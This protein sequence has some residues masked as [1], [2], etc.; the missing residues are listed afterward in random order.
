MTAPSIIKNIG[1]GAIWSVV[2]NS[3]TQILPLIVFL[4]TARFVSQEAFGIM[5][6]SILIVEAFRQIVVNP[7]GF[8]LIA[9]KDPSEEDYNACFITVVT[10]GSLFA[11]LIFLAAPL[12]ANVLGYPE[13][14]T[15]LHFV[16][17]MILFIGL[18]RV[19]EVWLIKNLQFKALASRSAASLFAGGA[20][21]IYMAVNGYGLASLIAQQIVT[22][23]TALIFLW[24]S[25]KW[26]P[27]FKTQWANIVELWRYTRFLMM[28]AVI[29]FFGMQTDTFF[30]G[31]YLGAAVTGTYNAAKRILAAL[32]MTLVQ[33]LNSVALPVFANMGSEGDRLGRAFLRSVRLTAIMAAP[34]YGG[35]LVLSEEAIHVL[36]GDNWLSAAPIMS[37]LIPAALISTISQY[38]ENIFLVHNKPQWPTYLTAVSAIINLG[39]FVLI[40][41]YGAV[42]LALA[43]SARAVIISPI[44]ISM[45]LYLL[46]LPLWHYIKQ[47]LPSLMAA[48]IMAICV[49]YLKQE[50]QS[51]HVLMRI[52][53]LVPVGAAIYI[54]A[55]ILLDRSIVKEVRSIISQVF[56]K[57]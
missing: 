14:E 33:A 17:P 44:N 56:K 40:A 46:K 23:I 29:S 24:A 53:I 12:L 48:T 25:T 45:A 49:Y 19:H 38:N 57:A 43:Y 21:G 31:Y 26:R 54:P 15:V 52:S 3:L 13:V 50:L 5:A 39:L 10:L 18:S 47:I 20:I 32:N 36:L 55:V 22:S 51:V 4:V 16:S 8:T 27:S 6:V 1:R 37:A 30:A 42:Y 28:S 35:L 7:F 41:K 34:L 9:K 11:V 2:N